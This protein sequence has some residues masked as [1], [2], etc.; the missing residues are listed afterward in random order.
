[1]FSATYGDIS[2]NSMISIAL[3]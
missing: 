2:S 1:M 3:Q